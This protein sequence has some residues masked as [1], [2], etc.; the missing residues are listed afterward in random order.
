M[1][2]K[3]VFAGVFYPDNHDE[4]VKS[5]ENSFT[6]S[7]GVGEVPNI[8]YF[9]EDEYPINVMVPHAGFQYSGSIASHS[10]CELAK[11]GFPEVFIIIGP[12]H[13]GLG[14]EVSVFSEGEWVTPLGNVQIDVEFADNLISFSDFASSD[15]SAHLRE[16]CIEVQLPFLQ[17]FSNDFKI[18]PIVMGTQTINS[19]IDLATAIFKTGEKLG[20]S[21]CVIAST[22]LSHFNTQER[23]NKVDKFVLE[24]IEDMDEFKLLE[25]I[26]QY[27]ITMCGYGSVMAAILLSKMCGKDTFE[28]LAYK[29]SGDVTGDLSSVV[30][31]ASG[32]FK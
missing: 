2:R 17:Y 22:D 5:I 32:I 9:E 31:Y 4:L 13:T 30:G 23:A 28:V 19:A 16:H 24:D 12:N 18:V 15:F 11:N 27:N 10:Y 1:L 29:T 6:N 26:I 7:F 20:K 25:E 8:G 3:P 21:Y 14:S